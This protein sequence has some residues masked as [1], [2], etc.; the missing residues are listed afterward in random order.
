MKKSLVIRWT[1]GAEYA[2]DHYPIEYQ[3]N[4]R[5]NEIIEIVNDL[6]IIIAVYNIRW[7]ISIRQEEDP[8]K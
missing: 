1:D 6:G 8:T 2:E 5:T 7:L 3:Q 4:F